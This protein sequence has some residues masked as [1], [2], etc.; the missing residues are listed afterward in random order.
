VLGADAVSIED[1]HSRFYADPL[2]SAQSRCLSRDEDDVVF[3]D[4]LGIYID[5]EDDPAAL[6]HYLSLHRRATENG[7][8]SHERGTDPWEKWR[9]L[10]EYQNHALLSRLADPEPYLVAIDERRH[11]FMD[12][13]DE[14][15]YT[16][17]GSAWYVMDRHSRM[18]ATPLATDFLPSTP[19]VYVFYRDGVRTYV[20]A[21]RDLL[22]RVHAEHLS[23]SASLQNSALRRSVAEHLG[24][25]SASDIRERR[26]QLT[27]A[28]LDQI[29]SW[30]QG[31]DV[32][33][34]ETET[35]TDAQQLAAELK[36]EL[37]PPLNSRRPAG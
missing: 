14:G 17:P 32:G 34:R 29:T 22:R 7:L 33:W 27:S 35:E 37:L 13:L 15:P 6:D 19:G 1:E 3:V 10:A 18:K 20:G 30:L 16:P 26:R 12:F 28:E 21:T 8:S 31:C 9:W 25:A 36:N 5:E 11:Q 4:H 23:T 24:I 2:Q